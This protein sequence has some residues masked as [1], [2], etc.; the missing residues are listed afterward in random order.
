MHMIYS[1]RWV[2]QPRIAAATI[3]DASN[4]SRGPLGLGN[5]GFLV[6]V[7]S[8]SALVHATA[9]LAL[10]NWS[11]TTVAGKGQPTFHLQWQPT[12]QDPVTSVR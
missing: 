1:D 5:S 10:Q 6:Q 8:Q 3:T 2:L 9:H 4:H 7:T 11:A 12:V